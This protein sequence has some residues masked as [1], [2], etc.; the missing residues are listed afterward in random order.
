MCFCTL[1]LDKNS[2]FITLYFHFLFNNQI[3]SMLPYFAYIGLFRE[4]FA[5]LRIRNVSYGPLNKINFSVSQGQLLQIVGDNGAGKTTLMK[6]MTGLIAA[7]ECNITFNNQSLFNHDFTY[8]GHQAAI[9]KK[10]TVLENCYW[11]AAL[12]GIKTGRSNNDFK[13]KINCF[14]TSLNLM[15]Y[16]NQFAENLSAGQTQRLALMRLKIKNVPIWILD[17]PAT[18]LDLTGRQWLENCLSDFLNS[19]GIAVIA[20][21]Q[22]L[23]SDFKPIILDL[24][25]GEV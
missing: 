1:N 24:S 8:I 12:A 20:T 17:E 22:S 25:R 11:M 13:D 23:F 18:S 4:I 2:L 19:G 3:A 6:I 16:H 7:E 10:L 15:Q 14:L 5:M 21:H 9:Q